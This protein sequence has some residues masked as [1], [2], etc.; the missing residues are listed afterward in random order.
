[1]NLLRTVRY[2][3]ALL[4]AG[5]VL[6]GCTV[7][8]APQRGPLDLDTGTF[9]TSPGQAPT[10]SDSGTR[11]LYAIR[12]GE[13]LI[14]RTDV[15]G[16]L[17]KPTMYN[18]PISG[19]N[20]LDGMV[21]FSAPIFDLE[22][23]RESADASD[24]PSSKNLQYGYLG[25]GH[26]GV[27][28]GANSKSLQ[29]AVLRYDNDRSAKTASTELAEVFRTSI[30]A[31]RRVTGKI[32]GLPDGESLTAE[33][34]YQPIAA[35]FIPHGRDLVVVSAISGDKRWAADSV[36][37]AVELQLKSMPPQGLEE[38]R[39][40][41]DE[42]LLA[43]TLPIE[44]TDDRNGTQDYVSGPRVRAQLYYDI[45]EVMAMFEAAGVDRISD[46][47]TEVFRT[48]DAGRAVTMQQTYVQARKDVG[49]VTVGSPRDLSSAI[50]TESDSTY[51]K[52]T[53]TV[54]V[55]RYFAVSDGETLIE[56]QQRISAQYLRLQ[57]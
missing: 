35:A 8:G 12:L 52:Y 32:A 21:Y 13:S 11:R 33:G 34:E 10:L 38:P 51:R 2:A 25:S 40:A 18:Y 28:S 1:M 16:D 43:R 5:V 19:L 14:F 22:E 46:R 39:S 24:A 27:D 20:N 36:R 4:A 26:N 17:T 29:H 49:E 3:A 55:D 42:D 54:A 47:E 15:D 44:D 48:A 23:N 31:Q 50:C 45:G 53:C 56:A 41:E 37:K 57:G 6:A 7:E 9:I 30:E